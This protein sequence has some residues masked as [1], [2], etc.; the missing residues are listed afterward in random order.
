MDTPASALSDLRVLDLTDLRGALCAKLMGDMG[1]DVIKIESPDGDPTRDIGPFLDASPDRSLL[2]WFYN[3]SKRGVTL[4]VHK[5][6]GQALFKRLVTNVDVVIESFPPGTL[7]R[8]GLGY[9]ALTRLNPQL[10]LTSITPF[11]Q[12]GPY[13]DY[14]SSD[15]VAEALGGMVYVNGFPD[16]PPLRGL[17]LQ[18]YHSAAFFGAIGTMSALW[19]RDCHRPGSVGR[20]QPARSRGRCGRARVAVLPPGFRR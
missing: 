11:G 12:S 19:A 16:E 4:D 13:A 15:T 3:T 5:P 17:G 2:Y 20:Y 9:D 10:V 1:A 14:K 7:D 8:L 6:A 18:A